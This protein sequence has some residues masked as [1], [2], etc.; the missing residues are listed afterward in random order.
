MCVPRHRARLRE[1]KRERERNRARHPKGVS[2]ADFKIQRDRQWL[3]R[4][5]LQYHIPFLSFHCLPEPKPALIIKDCH[6]KAL[7]LSV[8]PLP[9]VCTSPSYGSLSARDWVYNRQSFGGTR[10]SSSRVARVVETFRI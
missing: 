6:T 1:R 4:P 8:S 7:S 3:S 9:E 5:R 2:I 10:I